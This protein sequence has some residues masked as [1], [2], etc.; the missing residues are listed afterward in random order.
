MNYE[1]LTGEKY[2]NE[3]LNRETSIV[4][5]EKR[6]ADASEVERRL[7]DEIERLKADRDRRESEYLKKEKDDK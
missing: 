2:E 3:K 5:L 7:K 6:L 1:T 4:K